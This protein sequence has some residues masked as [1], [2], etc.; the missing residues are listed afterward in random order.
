[1]LEEHTNADKIMVGDFNCVISNS[2]DKKGG[3][4]HSNRNMQTTLASYLEDHDM[5]DIWR[6]HHPDKK[7]YT[8]HA[9][10]R[11]EHIFYKIRLFSCIIWLE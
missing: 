10:H 4:I 7:S 11:N 3:N 8:F 6:Q 5:I 1:M 2:L 9:K